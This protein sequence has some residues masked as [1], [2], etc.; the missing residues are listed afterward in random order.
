M[1]DIIGDSICVLRVKVEVENGF[2]EIVADK[3]ASL[4]GDV[5]SGEFDKNYP[6]SLIEHIEKNFQNIRN[7]E[8]SGPRSA[9]AIPLRVIKTFAPE[10]K[11]VFSTKI[12]DGGCGKTITEFLKKW[13]IIPALQTASGCDSKVEFKC[14]SQN[15]MLSETIIK[16]SSSKAFKHSFDLTDI[17]KEYNLC[18]NT[19]LLN[20]PRIGFDKAIE[21]V[22]CRE[23]PLVSLIIHDYSKYQNA[24]DYL[25]Y[26]EKSDYVFITAEDSDKSIT[27]QIRKALGVSTYEEI[28]EAIVNYK[29]NIIGNTSRRMFL[30]P[31]KKDALSKDKFVSFHLTGL[32]PVKVEVPDKIRLKMK[33][34]WL[35]GACVALARKDWAT[36]KTNAPFKL[37]GILPASQTD[38][39]TFANWAMNMAYFGYPNSD[40]HPQTNLILK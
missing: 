24:F 12:G 31:P 13:G 34:A 40:Y 3:I 19:L 2:D 37:N 16:K 27:S 28:G 26:V 1:S 11:V 8:I 17:E 33:T 36:C 14:V 29:T 30:L 5:K 23:N 35:N 25:K 21:I 7:I 18:C 6:L 20:R 10:N 9:I 38:F 32:K 39:E 15:G 4:Q 22:R